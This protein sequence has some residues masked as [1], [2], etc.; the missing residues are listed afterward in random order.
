M[1]TLLVCSCQKVENN[2]ISSVCPE[3]PI[4]Q[5]KTENV[6]K[7]DLT[8]KLI[9]ESGQLSQGT[10]L[11]YSFS[12]KVNQKLVYKT[13]QDIC[14]WLFTPDNQL[15]T[16]N[17][18]E[19]PSN[20]QYILQVSSRQGAQSFDLELG[21]SYPQDSST[22]PKTISPEQSISPEKSIENYY[23]NI[24]DRNYNKS[25]QSLSSNFKN[26]S[27]SNS[28]NDIFYQEYQDWWNKV[29]YV[30]INKIDVLEKTEEKATLKV[31]LQYQM[32]TG[33]LVQDKK[34]IF[35]L[36]WDEDSFNWLINKK[37]AP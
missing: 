7:I 19:L 10:M 33:N 27:G 35:Y 13:S 30:Q 15:L 12:G 29:D 11:G 32:K 34:S 18:T 31:D 25:W 1:L 4:S 8:E 37:I 24:N 20:G 22:S 9:T 5:L 36:V 3:K 17:A 16:S 6:K 21:L 28:E 26:P 2:P 23:K 14:I